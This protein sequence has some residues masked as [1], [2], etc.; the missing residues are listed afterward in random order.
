MAKVVLDSSVLIALLSN[1]DVHHGAAVKATSTKNLYAISAVS[2][3]EALI[4]PFRDGVKTGQEVRQV[5][6]K[7]MNQI[8]EIDE[9]IATLAAQIRAERSLLLPDALICATASRINAQ[10]WTFDRSL[11]KIHKGSLLIS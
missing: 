6:K 7:S 8:I 2:L 3:S 4:A 10:L 5:I 11:A 1:S 9:E